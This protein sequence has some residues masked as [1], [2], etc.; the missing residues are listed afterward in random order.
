[1]R[2]KQEIFGFVDNDSYTGFMATIKQPGGFNPLSF[3]CLCGAIR[4][5]LA[6]SNPV[7]TAKN[8]R[9]NRSKK[10][11]FCCFFPNFGLKK[12]VKNSYAP[13]VPLLGIF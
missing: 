2:N 11:V 10:S 6:G 12:G 3:E 4:F 7:G 5:L 1:M 8:K 9:K 13:R